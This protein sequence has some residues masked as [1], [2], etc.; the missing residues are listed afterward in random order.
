MT[1]ARFYFSF[2]SPYSWLGYHDLLAR[3][4]D[5]AAAVEWRPLWEP[6]D[7]LLRLL[8]ESGARFPYVGMSR[9]K[10]LYILADVRRL[11]R[12]RGLSMRWPVDHAPHWEVAHLAYLA[13]CRL[14]H[15]APFVAAVYRARWE[16]GRDISDPG[17]IGAIGAELGLDPR[18][19]AEAAGNPELRAEGLRALQAVARDGVFG[20][21]F[22][23]LGHERFW[24][25]D[26]LTDF[27]EALRGGQPTAAGIV[28]PGEIVEPGGNADGGEDTSRDEELA[29]E[30][31]HAGGCG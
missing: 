7:D 8:T 2:R 18:P 12:R 26:R 16:C 24:G 27:A 20:V 28:E 17:V 21:P 30:A 25:V 3:F 10:S 29:A 4:P 13:A 15:G 11:A 23:V 31:G 5:V 22:F 14:G 19:L 9:P 1:A 6:D